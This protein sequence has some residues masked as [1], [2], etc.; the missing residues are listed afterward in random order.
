MDG[1]THERTID[2]L[3]AERDKLLLQIEQYQKL[4]KRCFDAINQDGWPE[5]SV[6]V[7]KA[8]N[9]ELA[10]KRNEIPPIEDPQPVMKCPKCG[11]DWY[12]TEADPGFCGNCKALGL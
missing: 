6:E 5:L 8:M 12:A 1:W 9:G 4:L 7:L 11:I 10:V 3:R 2:E